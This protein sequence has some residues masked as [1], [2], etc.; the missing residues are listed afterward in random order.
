MP[1]LENCT[2]SLI[3]AVPT[4]DHRAVI[5]SVLELA[6]TA[7]LLHRP[8]RF[9]IGDGSSS[10]RARNTIL[11]MLQQEFPD[12]PTLWMLWWNS[13]IVL[14]PGSAP[15]LSQAIPWAEAHQM[16]MVADPRG[17]HENTIL[18]A[19][20]ALGSVSESSPSEDMPHPTSYP[21]TR[22]AGLGLAYLAQPLA[23][24]FHADTV[25]EDLHFWWGH[26]TIHPHRIDSLPVGLRTP[27][28]LV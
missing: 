6:A 12:H 16:C 24:R 14:F 1:H 19:T 26:P 28:V 5:Q 9:V 20:P 4:Y 27:M 23:Y 18:H 8:I 7:E 22:L 25:G 15:V 21:K 13:D 3:V 17:A 11:E 10:P 2:A